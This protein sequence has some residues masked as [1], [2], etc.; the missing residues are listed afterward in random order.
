[1]MTKPEEALEAADDV[2]RKEEKVDDVYGRVRILLGKEDLVKAGVT[3]LIG[4]LF[5]A[6]KV[7]GDLCEDAC[8]QVRVIMV[9]K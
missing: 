5:E 6:V 7:I 2:E 1:M 9:R 4:Q 3:V 8:D